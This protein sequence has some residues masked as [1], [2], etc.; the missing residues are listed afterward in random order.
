M[1]ESATRAHLDIWKWRRKIF[2]RASRGMMGTTRL[3][4]PDFGPGASTL[5]SISHPTPCELPTAMGLIEPESHSN[6]P[7]FTN[8][9]PLNPEDF[10]VTPSCQAKAKEGQQV[11][12]SCASCTK[13][14]QQQWSN[15]K[16]WEQPHQYLHQ[17]PNCYLV[18]YMHVSGAKCYQICNNDWCHCKTKFRRVP[19]V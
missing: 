11:M 4:L 13:H 5:W 10:W 1:Y 2:F 17:V 16:H 9:V 15:E 7:N 3:Y 14:H 19:P 6:L 8:K 18:V 12:L